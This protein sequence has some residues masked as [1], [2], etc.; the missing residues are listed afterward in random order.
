MLDVT[1]HWRRCVYVC[2]CVSKPLYVLHHLAIDR[3]FFPYHSTNCNQLTCQLIDFAMC[4]LNKL[5]TVS[6]LP[7]HTP[8][9]TASHGLTIVYV[10]AVK[11]KST[12]SH[13][14]QQTPTIESTVYNP[15]NESLSSMWLANLLPWTICFKPCVV[16]N[17][18]F[19]Q[20]TKPVIGTGWPLCPRVTYG[21][22]W[23]TLNNSV[24]IR[25][26]GVSSSWTVA[27]TFHPVKSAFVPSG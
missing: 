25:P 21:S 26:I 17:I 27:F 8:N 15:G 18:Y 24:N 2:V 22:K 10:N 6:N 16:G 11:C 9:A 14:R 12:S 19:S 7:I 23:I 5:I 1:K 13:L 20:L 3:H 4:H